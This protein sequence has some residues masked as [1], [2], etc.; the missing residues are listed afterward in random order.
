MCSLRH[1]YRRLRCC[2]HG[3]AHG[4]AAHMVLHIEVLHTW[5]ILDIVHTADQLMEGR[6]CTLEDQCS[7]V[8]CIDPANGQ[9]AA[10]CP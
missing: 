6:A 2:T 3:T 8:Q 9:H 10:A 5:W 1:G 7:A 4:G